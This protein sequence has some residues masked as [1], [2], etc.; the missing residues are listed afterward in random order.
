MFWEAEIMYVPFPGFRTLLT[1]IFWSSS[2]KVPHQ[3]T[4]IGNVNIAS[5]QTCHL[6]RSYRYS[7][8][9]CYLNSLCVLFWSSRKG[10]CVRVGHIVATRLTAW[11]HSSVSTDGSVSPSGSHKWSFQLTHISFG[12]IIRM[13]LR[14][15]VHL[16]CDDD[17]NTLMVS[18]ITIKVM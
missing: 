10:L 1:W 12:T 16:W 13:S 8:T 17:G 7:M 9:L 14:C 18:L 5:L 6:T 2:A 11:D 4:I 15:G 3:G